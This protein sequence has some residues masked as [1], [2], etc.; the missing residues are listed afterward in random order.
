MRIKAEGFA[1]GDR[2]SL[3]LP[4]P[5]ERLLE[6]VHA[7]GKPVV[8]VVTSGSALALNWRMHMCRQSST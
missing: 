7:T 1:G 2:T 8:L 3:D 6:A 4:A 5:Q